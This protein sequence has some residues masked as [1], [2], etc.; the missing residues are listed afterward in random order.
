MKNNHVWRTITIIAVY[1]FVTVLFIGR[2]IYLQVSGQDYYSM[3]MPSRQYTRTVSIQAQRGEIYDRNG[4]PLVV[5]H[6]SYDISADYS[7]KPSSGREF[8]DML[9]DFLL[10]ADRSGADVAEPKDSLEVE[11]L[12]DGL[13]FTKPEGF[14]ETVRG[15]RYAKLVSE[16]HPKAS[17]GTDGE[18]AVLL[19]YFGITSE[20][21]GA[22]GKTETFCNYTWANA[23]RLFLIRLDMELSGFSPAQ[24]YVLASNATTD[25]IAAVEE[26]YSTGF[27]VSVRSSR[28]YLYPGYASHILGLVNKIPAAELEQY[29]E[30]GYPMDAVVG[31]SGAEAAFEDYL[32]G[33]DGTLT[34]TED[35]YGNVLSAEV[36]KEPS[37][38]HDVYLTIDID[39]QMT[40]ERALAE[41]I[42][43][44]REEADPDK[45][46]TGE[47]A[48][49]GALTVLDADTFEVLSLCSYPTFNLAT[50]S[51]DYPYLS[52][53]Q[54]K[55]MFNRAL[56]GAYAPGSTFKIGVAVAALS[57][58]TITKDTIIEDEGIYR[59]YE[60]SKYTPRCWLYLLTNGQ[61]THGRINVV[62]A[63][64]E[65]CNYFFYEVGRNLTISKMNEYCRKYGLGQPTGIE[66]P[67]STGILAGPDYRA[68]N[69][70]GQW[71]P[72]DT[73]QAAIGQ[74]D[75]QFT[76]LQ[77]SIYLA[78]VL[79]GG[80]RYSASILHSVKDYA[81]GRVIYSRTPKVLDTV[82]IGRDILSTVKEGMR[83]VMD[84]GSAASVFR[85]YEISVGGKTGTAQVYE[86]K[87]DN[88]IMTAFAPFE[89][90]EI[91]V[92][93]VIE[94][95]S[96]GTQAGYAVRDVM[97]Y[98]FREQIAA[99][100][101]ARGEN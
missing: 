57:E 51:R 75:N 6:Y 30:K 21:K 28:Q 63:I 96:G 10:C 98:Y 26:K 17:E 49:S 64:Q 16:L 27:L 79:N 43:K 39:M 59:Y 29:T 68:E 3:S 76:P 66:L 100:R 22:S 38:G 93:C 11:V 47:D 1:G 61:Q 90:P 54:L 56:T 12:A 55:P 94:Q 83:G 7:S 15:K 14:E 25:L 44:I 45:P 20:E 89:N 101:E 78:T 46:L 77:I 72:G 67:E 24:P 60:N 84:N 23:K 65:S 50:F 37:P 52:N 2:L 40:A 95:G 41:N 33:S 35:E 71:S 4:R 62:E 97:D 92:T 86:N 5:N 99:L 18:G 91:V 13:H 87:S 34:I 88:G 8:N 19:K 85:G 73:L 32:R 69:G 42:M 70:L 82:D 48:Y 80:T 81:T 36:T 74:S 53:D 58:G 9:L 31:I